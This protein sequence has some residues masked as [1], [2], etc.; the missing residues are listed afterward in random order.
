MTYKIWKDSRLHKTLFVLSMIISLTIAPI[1]SAG[2]VETGV[3]TN[4]CS[5]GNM[6]FESGT[7]GQTIAS[8]IPGL[9]FT[10]TGGVN[11]VIGDF[12]TGG[13]NG[14]YPNGDYTSDG[15]K[16]AWLGPFQGAGRIDFTMRT[17]TYLSLL[18]STKSGIA[19]EA[20]D[21]SNNL[22]DR[23]PA[24]GLTAPNT[25]T[26]YMDRLNVSAP[27]MAY[28]IVHDDS[29]FFIVD[30]ICTDAIGSA[31]TVSKDFRFTDVSFSEKPAELGTL[32]PQNGSKF[33]V[34]YVTKP[35]DGTVSSTNPGQLYGVITINGTG[36]QNVNMVDTF[37]TQFKVNPAKLGGGVEVLRVN[38][39]TGVATDI[40][41]TPQ[42]TSA[43]VDNTLHTV[44]LTINLA[45]PL[46]VDEKLMIYVKFQTALKGMLPDTNDFVNMADIVINGG[47]PQTATATINFVGA[48]SGMSIGDD[49][50]GCE[51]TSTL[52]A[53]GK[54]KNKGDDKQD[55][56]S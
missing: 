9:Q 1:A 51:E 29:N 14:K 35:K 43:S 8:T 19:L 28:V 44:K 30:D 31:F 42:V 37:G 38:T 26:G 40:T 33:N 4:P 16:W 50:Q 7:D 2:T 55:C 6:D 46:A 3:T 48:G 23:A 54:G 32:L 34:T 52:H 21:A 17:A 47:T 27:G 41:N 36:A 45:A 22:L 20:Y 18:A 15:T 25:G 5:A 56:E 13:Y 11:W 39:T 49:E 53:A 24:V 10:T 12:A